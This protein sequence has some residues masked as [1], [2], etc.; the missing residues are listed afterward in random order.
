MAASTHGREWVGLKSVCRRGKTG[1]VH[2]MVTSLNNPPRLMGWRT[3]WRKHRHTYERPTLISQHVPH[4]SSQ[5]RDTDGLRFQHVNTWRTSPALSALT[6][7]HGKVQAAPPTPALLCCESAHPTLDSNVKK[8]P[9]SLR[10]V[11]PQWCHL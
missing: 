8:S 4:M 7:W 9:T 6:R 11:L 5:H 1:V 3:P 10:F 2:F